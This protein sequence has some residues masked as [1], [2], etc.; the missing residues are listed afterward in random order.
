MQGLQRLQLRGRANFSKYLMIELAL[1]KKEWKILLP[2]VIMQCTSP[3]SLF[4]HNTT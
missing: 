3:Y 1:L 4:L 2:C